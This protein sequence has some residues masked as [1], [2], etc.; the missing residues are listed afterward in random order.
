MITYVT[1]VIYVSLQNMEPNPENCSIIRIWNS[2]VKTIF[3]LELVET[4]LT[5][6]VYLW[7]INYLRKSEYEIT[8]GYIPINTLLI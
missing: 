4:T 3:K 5:N 7:L 2:I 6:D 1:K 8:R